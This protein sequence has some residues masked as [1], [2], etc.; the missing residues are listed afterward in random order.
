[1][2]NTEQL[3]NA[4]ISN[5]EVQIQDFASAALDEKLRLA[6]D[7]R[8]VGLTA[9]IF[10]KTVSESSDIDEDYEKALRVKTA[11]SNTKTS[12]K[13]K[14]DTLASY[15]RSPKANTPE[16]REKIAKVK[17]VLL[18]LSAQLQNQ[19]AYLRKVQAEK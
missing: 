16:Y 18:D 1:M 5:D 2:K 15:Q 12:I 9:N 17:E 3:F 10:N 13:A 8:K 7:I 4:L 11:I 19:E 14:Q 6:F